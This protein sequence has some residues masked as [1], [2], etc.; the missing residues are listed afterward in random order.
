M[1]LKR[2]WIASPNYSSRGGAGVRLIVLHTAEGATTYQSLGSYFQGD[3][4]VSSHVGIDDTLGTIG[5]YVTRGNK[6]WTQG[7]ANPVAVAAEMC[8]FASWSESTWRN[9]HANMLNNTARWVAE[10]AG[11][12]G[13]PI[14]KLSASQAQGSGRGVCQHRDLGSWGGNHSDCGNGFPIDYVLSMAVDMFGGGGGSTTPP[15]STGEKAPPLHVDYFGQDHNRTCGDVQVWQAQMSGRGWAIDVDGEFG[16]QSEDV[17]RSFQSEK[18]LDSD[19]LVGPQTW[20]TTWSA[21]VT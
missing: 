17:C 4:G 11:K 13:I 18:G 20:E 14:T 10:E 12:F 2:V 6:A 5:E 21:P 15:P 8:A 1:G 16:P 9:S 3:V 19:G 7:N